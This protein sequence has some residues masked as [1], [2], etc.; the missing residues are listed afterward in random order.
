M[1][2]EFNLGHISQKFSKIFAKIFAKSAGRPFPILGDFRSN[3]YFEVIS[4]FL[5]VNRYKVHQYDINKMSFRKSSENFWDFM[6]FQ[7]ILGG[8]MKIR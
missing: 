5:T 4:M 2:G 3:L 7:D 8:K 6:S 1:L